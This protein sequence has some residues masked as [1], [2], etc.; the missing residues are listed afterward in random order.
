MTHDHRRSCISD[1]TVG[2]YGAMMVG[3]CATTV[4]LGVDDGSLG[5]LTT[6]PDTPYLHQVVVVLDV[7]QTVVGTILRSIAMRIPA[8]ILRL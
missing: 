4:F 6:R 2:S 1:T 3:Y 5:S 7:M 8:V